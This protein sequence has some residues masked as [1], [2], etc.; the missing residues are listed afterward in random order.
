MLTVALW[1]W[2][3]RPAQEPAWPERIQGFCLSP[4]HAEQDP[5]AGEH[6][7]L[8]QIDAD[9]AFIRGK[10]HAVRTYTVEGVM[11]EIPRLAAAHGINVALGAWLDRRLDHNERELERLLGIAV[12]QRNVVRVIVGNEAILRGDRS[13]RRMVGYLDRARAQL[14][15]P[16]STAE[17]WNVWKAHPE[18][19]AHVDYLAVHML[20]YWEGV[21]VDEAVQYVVDRIGELQSLYPGKPIV[22]AEVGWPSNGRARRGAEASPANEAVFMRRFLERARVE[23]Y[24]YYA[25]EAF[26]QP[27]KRATEGAVGAYWGIWNVERQPK[28]EFTAPVVEVPRWQLLAALSVVVAVVALAVLLIDSH[29][30]RARGRGFLAIIAFAAATGAV[31]IV[32]DFSRQYLTLASGVTGFI[33]VVGGVGVIA[34]VF[35]EAHEWAESLWVRERRRPAILRRAQDAELP[36]VS[37]H[38]PTYNEPP[39][40][41]CEVL[42]ALSR[43][44]YPD[45]EVLVIDNNTRDPQTWQPV[46]ECCAALGPR[47]RFFH[48]DPLAGFKAGALNFA[49]QHTRADAG[50][51]AV[52]DSDYVVSPDWLRELVPQ[53]SSPSIAIVQAPQDYRDARGGAFKAMCYAE[54]LGFFYVGMRTRND[55]NAIIQHGTMTLVR[56]SV[57]EEVGGWAQWCITE[58][59]ELGLRILERG[60]E[61]L[62]VPKSYGRGL[63]P[64]TFLDYKKQRFRW[65][66]G[67]VQILRRHAAALLGPGS[68]GLTSGQRYHF[69]AGWMPWIADGLNLVFTACAVV[70][71]AAII[72]APERV[73]PP[74]A[75]FSALPLT[76][77][78]F[79]V[80][81]ILYL[82]R[83]Q[84]KATAGQMIA[85]AVSG[86]ALSHTIGTAVMTGI[87]GSERPFFRT[88]KLAD[89]QPLRQAVAAAREEGLIL[90]ALWL[91]AAGLSLYSPPGGVDILLWKAMVAALSLPYLS[92]VLVSV[93]SALP[94]LPVRWFGGMAMVDDVPAAPSWVAAGH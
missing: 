16:V 43:I 83:S 35:M 52:I 85:A 82:Y 41:L 68:S 63:M 59:A 42:A 93:A 31:W 91:A 75:A 40:M 57:I 92:A 79:K 30:L 70:W 76:L 71:S 36:V 60:Y 13:V 89:A 24:I 84:V 66:F 78:V 8:A 14:G 39:A 77:L 9:L 81:K 15:V 58:D 44:D 2:A 47:F 55:R 67:A 90:I 51:V 25:M 61:A 88:P 5:L 62:Y 46:R 64:D 12:R 3:N 11:G 23:G 65:A 4:Y 74:M 49:L 1:A 7:T 87:A 56:R 17:P 69:I 86:L 48:V 19:A 22:I 34:V 20:P 94:R 33:L 37:I 18:L 45:Y 29:T 32:Y 72:A 53:F 28:F 50:V 38:V 21:P 27:W 10:S 26:D 54:Y 73:D 6:P 80:V